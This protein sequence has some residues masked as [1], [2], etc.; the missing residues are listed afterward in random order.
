MISE[1]RTT[2]IWSLDVQV[3]VDETILV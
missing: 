3:K 1:L 2:T